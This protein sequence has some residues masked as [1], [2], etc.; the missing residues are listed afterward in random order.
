MTENQRDAVASLEVACLH[1]EAPL[2]RLERVLHPWV[3]FA[4]MPIFALANAGVMLGAGAG[5]GVGGFPRWRR[6]MLHATPREIHD[7]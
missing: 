5:A 6:L 4:I 2:T 7:R 1:V 3:A